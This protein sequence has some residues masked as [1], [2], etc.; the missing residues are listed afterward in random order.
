MSK[1]K[2][3][4][5]EE[6]DTAGAKALEDFNILIVEH[7]EAVLLIAEWWQKWYGRAGHRRLGRILVKEG[8]RQL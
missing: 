2:E 4:I 8:V 6:M 7:E 5:R 3:Q 1:S